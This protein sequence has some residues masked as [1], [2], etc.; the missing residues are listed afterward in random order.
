M[1]L[2]G[3]VRVDGS[4]QKRPALSVK[5]GAKIALDDPAAAYVSRA[6]LK[7]VTG[8]D[9]ARI[10][11]TAKRCLDLGC[12]TGGFSQVLLERGAAHVFGIEVGSGQL[13]QS[14]SG[15][16]RLTVLENTNARDLTL[17]D[18]GDAAPQ[19]IVS[20]L[21]FIPLRLGAEPGLRLAASQA[22]AVLLVKP[23]FE[24]GRNA[25]GKAGI[26]TNEQAIDRANRDVQDWF[27]SLPGW[28]VTDFLPSPIKGG[29]GNREFL[30][31]GIRQTS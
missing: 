13:A 21:S 15:H 27:E 2:R 19:I 8:L 17:N 29:D 22:A 7:L 28:R 30:L 26:V 1:I 9:R 11:V 4:V 10:D 18:L 24:V 31:C 20:D 25:I 16:P 3:C 14:L 23:Q 12:S 6:A 5:P